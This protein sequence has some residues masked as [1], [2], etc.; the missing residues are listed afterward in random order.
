MSDLNR[1]VVQNGFDVFGLG[2]F[3]VRILLQGFTLFERRDLPDGIV[4]NGGDQFFGCCPLENALDE[5]Y[6]FVDMFPVISHSDQQVLKFFDV[7][8]IES[9]RGRAK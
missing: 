8:G 3:P 1:Q 2:I 9:W 6:L 4:E 7:F 5:T